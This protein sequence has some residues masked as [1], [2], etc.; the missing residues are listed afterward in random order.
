MN[1][2]CICCCHW[3]DQTVYI[4]EL[5]ALNAV[6]ECIQLYIHQLRV[7]CINLKH[8][9]MSTLMNCGVLENEFNVRIRTVQTLNSCADSDQWSY[10]MENRRQPVWF[11]V[12]QPEVLGQGDPRSELLLHTDLIFSITLP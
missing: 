11:I 2:K 8:P 12:A 5:G 6:V 1:Y 3:N 10:V 7:N 9:A 4:A